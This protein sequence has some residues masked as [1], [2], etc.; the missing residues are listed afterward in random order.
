[1]LNKFY[2]SAQIRIMIIVAVVI[3]VALTIAP[4]VVVLAD[5]IGGGH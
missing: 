4:T 5:Q 3:V 2:V 1:M